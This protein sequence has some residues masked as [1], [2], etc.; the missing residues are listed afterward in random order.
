MERRRRVPPEP[1]LR[2]DTGEESWEERGVAG[3]KT[4]PGRGQATGAASGWV[5]RAP[6]KKKPSIRL[7]AT[8]ST[9]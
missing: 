2:D 9:A 1:Q 7:E 6:G 5:N 8:A 4:G 3:P